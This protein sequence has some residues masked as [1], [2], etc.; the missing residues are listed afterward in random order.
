MDSLDMLSEDDECLQRASAYCL[1]DV[2][3]TSDILHL[4]IEKQHFL[5]VY[6]CQPVVQ[7]GGFQYFFES[8]WPGNPPYDLF[9]KAYDAI[10]SA[11]ASRFLSRAVALF[12]FAD[13]HLQLSARVRF[14]RDHCVGA[15]SEMGVLSG[16]MMDGSDGVFAMLARY[17]REH[18]IVFGGV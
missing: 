13:P 2:P 10:G 8:D 3:P 12:P 5:R 6:T 18:S 16:L 14:L 1:R 7:I 17:V 9:T 11:E 15:D 4:S